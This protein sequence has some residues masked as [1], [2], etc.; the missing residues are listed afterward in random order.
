ML[1]L[2]EDPKQRFRVDDIEYEQEEGKLEK[3]K[4]E[5]QEQLNE[6]LKEGWYEGKVDEDYIKSVVEVFGEKDFA[7]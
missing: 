4:M 5:L 7:G 6:K 2:T 1:G 3:I